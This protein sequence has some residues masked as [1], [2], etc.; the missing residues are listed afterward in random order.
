MLGL[1][2]NHVSKS[3]HWLL[4]H[5]AVSFSGIDYDGLNRHHFPPGNISTTILHQLNTKIYD[6]VFYK[7]LLWQRLATSYAIVD[8]FVVLVPIKDTQ[9]VVFEMYSPLKINIQLNSYWGQICIS[10][11]L[12][13]FHM[14]VITHPCPNL[15]EALARPIVSANEYKKRE[16][17]SKTWDFCQMKAHSIHCY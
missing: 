4:T 14:S 5:L 7:H 2:L 17:T 11:C 10:I 6:Y 9:R 3:G 12:A 13:P 8:F 1:K 16:N 15:N